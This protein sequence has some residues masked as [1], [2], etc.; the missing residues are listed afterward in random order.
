MHTRVALILFAA[1]AAACGSDTIAHELTEKEANTI[2]E[3]LFEEG[4]TARTTLID[5]GRAKSYNVSVPAAKRIDAIKILNEH[6][7]PRRK[8]K[9]Y[10]DIFG[11]GGLIPT[12]EQERAKSL[13]ALEGEIERQ[14][15]LFEGVLDAQVQLVVPRDETLRTTN[16][17]VPPTTAAVTIK[18]LPGAGGAKP[19]AE[20]QIKALV[21]AGVEK[22]T[23]DRVEVVM[24]PAGAAGPPPTPS[25]CPKGKVCIVQKSFTISLAGGLALLV[26]LSLGIVYGQVR[27]RTVRGKLIKL[28]TEIA[29]ARKKPTDSASAPA[30]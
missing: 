14:L 4:I 5:T 8:D 16:D 29:R 27:L 15:K 26:L 25:S 18:Y 13:A 28:Q 2:I 1:T 3:V 12:A 30:A 22:L 10:E 7:L 21:A 17:Q 9:G 11:Q 24:A 6:E 23:S 19:L 20:P